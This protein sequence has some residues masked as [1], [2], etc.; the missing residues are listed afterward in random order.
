ME[1]PPCKSAGD[2]PR[3][4]CSSTASAATGTASR[5]PRPRCRRAGARHSPAKQTAVAE[6]RAKREQARAPFIRFVREA[7][8]NPPGE[9]RLRAHAARYSVMA[10]ANDVARLDLRVCGGRAIFKMFDLE[11]WYRD[12]RCGS[13]MLPWTAEICLERPGRESPFEADEP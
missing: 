4:F 6:L 1:V 12:G 3:R 7:Q 8:P 5:T 2:A 11:R 10:L 13:P 9:G